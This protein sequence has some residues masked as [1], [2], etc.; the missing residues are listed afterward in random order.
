M[1][2][3]QERSEQ[4]YRWI[5]KNRQLGTFITK[6]IICYIKPL[7]VVQAPSCD[8]LSLTFWVLTE[9]NGRP[10]NLF[11]K[12]TEVRDRL[13]ASG[14]DISVLVQPADLIAKLKKH[15]KSMRG[16]KDYIVQ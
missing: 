14:R 3:A 4:I 15:L 5:P 12:D 9:I 13:N 11:F 2:R 1:R 10:L 8:G 7:I 6:E 16:Y